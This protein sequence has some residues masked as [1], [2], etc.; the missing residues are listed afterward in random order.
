MRVSLGDRKM[1]WQR[2]GL[3]SG[4]VDRGRADLP[5]SQLAAGGV[6]YYPASYVT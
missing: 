1:I 6:V 2:S 4:F 5:V 3:R